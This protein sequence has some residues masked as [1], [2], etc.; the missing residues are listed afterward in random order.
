MSGNVR[1]PSPSNHPSDWDRG[2]NDYGGVRPLVLV[3]PLG[4]TA[5]AIAKQLDE[6][7]GGA[8]SSAP[9]LKSGTSK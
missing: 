8:V 3:S 4:I 7:F 9:L 2:S 1:S 6:E 5:A